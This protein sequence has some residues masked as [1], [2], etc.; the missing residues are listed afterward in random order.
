MCLF[1]QKK[2]CLEVIPMLESIFFAGML[3]ILSFLLRKAILALAEARAA[4]MLSR[5][6]RSAAVTVSKW[7]REVAISS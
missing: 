4:V 2:M 3:W 5:L 6:V 7:A 1:L